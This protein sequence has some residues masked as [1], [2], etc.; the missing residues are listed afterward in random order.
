MYHPQS[1][2]FCAVSQVPDATQVNS[3]ATH[4]SPAMS[5]TPI[6]LSPRCM[7]YAASGPLFRAKQK[8][9]LDR[10]W[11]LLLASA[12]QV[13]YSHTIQMG[14][15]LGKGPCHSSTL[16][17]SPCRPRMVVVSASHVF[18]SLHRKTG[19]LF[20]AKFPI[21][22][23]PRASRNLVLPHAPRLPLRMCL[24]VCKY[25]CTFTHSRPLH[26]V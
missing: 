14:V 26:G 3:T 18:S 11:W 20:T 24:I 13:L 7:I 2:P 10:V 4:Y 17:T 23:K 12:T 6:L 9:F 15:P 19:M 16:T 8:S 21:K 22:C 25:A 1:G 5:P